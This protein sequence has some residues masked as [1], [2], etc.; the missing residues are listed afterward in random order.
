MESELI[1]EVN[2]MEVLQ[3]SRLFQGMSPEEINGVF[4][5]MDAKEQCYEKG[6]FIV[7]QG[8]RMTQLY[9]VVKGMVHIIKSDYWGNQTIMSEAGPGEIFGEAYAEFLCPETDTAWKP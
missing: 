3:K 6:S 9:V 2:A 4:G 5:C 7:N 8:D 1:K